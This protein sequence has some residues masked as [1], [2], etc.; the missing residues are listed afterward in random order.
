[1]ARAGSRQATPCHGV[2]SGAHLRCSAAAVE[3]FLRRR[4]RL[5]PDEVSFARRGFRGADPAVR[6]HLEGVGGA[7][8]HG[9][10]AA[11]AEARLGD[12]AGRLDE[13]PAAL[14]GFAFEGAAM[15]LTLLDF[16]VPWSRG[17]LAAL[18][19]GAGRPHS[20]L[21]HVGAGWALGRLPL[22]PSLLAR[23]LDPVQRWLVLDG[24]GFHEGFFGWRRSIDGRRVPLRLSG[25]ARRVFDQGLGRSLWFVRAASPEGIAAAIGAF[26]ASRRAD[27]WS[28]AGLACAYA[29][30]VTRAAIQRL[31]QL[32][33]GF[34]PQLA[35]GAA[36]AAKARQVA[37][38][39][40]PTTD[41]A[42]QVLCGTT[43]AAAAAA[44]DAAEQGMPASG[45][46]PAYEGWRR[47]TQ[48]FF[49]TR[50][51]AACPSPT[52]VSAA[53]P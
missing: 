1:M 51:E 36:F 53:A 27:L 9:Y 6:T 14:R 28:G 49:A 39:E 29:G 22:P 26:P 31:R 46:E 8:V 30:G 35:Q 25:Y 21:V 17:R 45:G 34:E 18:L 24:F 7:F 33:A 37:G 41:L 12:L 13:T 48:E 42:C 50:R 19:A 15:A 47:R 16:L 32:G 40:T 4:L 2:G 43:A 5:S 23:R 38:N 52:A 44:T 20:Y 3:R 11:L 10:N